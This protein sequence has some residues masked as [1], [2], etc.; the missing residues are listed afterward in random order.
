MYKWW[1]KLPAWLLYQRR[2]VK[3]SAGLH[4]T[5]GREAGDVRRICAEKS[6]CCAT[7]GV[8]ESDLNMPEDPLPR[9]DFLFLG[10][11]HPV[12]NLDGLLKAWERAR[13]RGR[14][15]IAGPDDVGHKA[16]LASLAES[17]GLRIVDIVEKTGCNKKQIHGGMEVSPEVLCRLLD[18][19]DADVVFAGPV[20][21]AAKDCLL[22]S[23][24]F[25]VLPSHSENFGLVVV[26]A[27]A[28][29]VPVIASDGTPWECLGGDEEIGRCGWHCRQSLDGLAEALQLAMKCDGTEYLS[30]CQNAV[31]LARR[32]F[33][34]RASA[35]KLVDFYRDIR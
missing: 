23:S 18:S 10:R 4:V 7:L 11:I 29:G 32:R 2:D 31:E 28:R 30:L 12:K 20:Y 19:A 34:W 26:E 9:K 14:L 33:T 13:P 15:I 6:I 17:M 22:D 5:S 8:R 21:S 24:R 35:K 27:L 1:K 16:E 25:L 3:C